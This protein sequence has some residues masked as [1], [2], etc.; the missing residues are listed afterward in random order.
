MIGLLIIGGPNQR[1]RRLSLLGIAFVVSGVMFLG[2]VDDEM[3]GSVSAI[4]GVLVVVV[5][6]LTGGPSQ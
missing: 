4:V 5:D 1:V 2:V 3:W 6:I